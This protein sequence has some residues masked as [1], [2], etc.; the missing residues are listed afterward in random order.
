MKE[1]TNLSRR[2][3]QRIR[4]LE[5]VVRKSMSLKTGNRPYGGLLSP[6]ETPGRRILPAGPADMPSG[7]IPAAKPIFQPR[8]YDPSRDPDRKYRPGFFR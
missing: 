3:V 1:L 8:H 5:Q 4:V 6:G 7:T 2:A